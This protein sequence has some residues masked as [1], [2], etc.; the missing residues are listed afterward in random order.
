M[1]SI[2]H[3]L[4]SFDSQPIS[5]SLYD[6][7]ISD[8]T[9]PFD[10][11]ANRFSAAA[12]YTWQ[13]DVLIPTGPT[14][15]QGDSC[16]RRASVPRRGAYSNFCIIWGIH[17]HR[18]TGKKTTGLRCQIEVNTYFLGILRGILFYSIF[19]RTG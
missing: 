8:K 16:F 7:T 1:S 11:H 14:V 15:H 3:P 13:D 6:I 9:F 10:F 17:L 18:S 5:S 2:D 4:F 12:D 19:C